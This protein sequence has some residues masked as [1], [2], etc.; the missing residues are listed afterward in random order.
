[1]PGFIRPPKTSRLPDI[2]SIAQLQAILNHTRILSYR[3]LFFTR[4][5]MCVCPQP[6]LMRRPGCGEPRLSWAR[7]QERQERHPHG[8]GRRFLVAAVATCFAQRL[9]ASPQLWGAAPQRAAHAGFAAIDAGPTRSA[10]SGAAHAPCLALR[11]WPAHGDLAQAHAAIVG[12][13]KL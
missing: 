12:A 5:C 6:P 8:P 2:V 9:A 1:M 4:M 13:A 7:C 3:V 11:L 10:S